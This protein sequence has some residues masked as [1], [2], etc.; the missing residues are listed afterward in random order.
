MAWLAAK[1]YATVEQPS[2]GDIV[3]PRRPRDD[4]LLSVRI[5]MRHSVTVV[6]WY[7]CVYVCLLVTTVSCAETDEPIEVPFAVDLW[8]PRYP[9]FPQQEGGTYGG[10]PRLVRGRILNLVRYEATEMRPMAS[11]LL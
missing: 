5:A 3:S 2:A 7:I 6:T 1:R 11:S 9:G 10:M 4:T 8:G